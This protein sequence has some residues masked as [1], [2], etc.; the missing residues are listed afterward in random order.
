VVDT[1]EIA[2]IQV[3]TDDRQRNL[4]VVVQVYANDK[5]DALLVDLSAF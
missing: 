4:L 2:W 5:S 3:L 1:L